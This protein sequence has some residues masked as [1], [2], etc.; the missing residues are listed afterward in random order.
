MHIPGLGTV[1]WIDH[2]RFFHLQRLELLME[3]AQRRL[4]EPG[5]DFAGIAQLAT[6][7]V[8][9][10]QQQRAE[11]MARAFRLGESDDYELLP[12]LAFELDPVAAAPGDIGRPKTLADQALHAHPAGAVEQGVRLLAKRLGEAQQRLVIGL[13]HSC[14]RSPTFFDR[15][16]A[17]VH[18]IEVRQVEQVVENAVAALRLEGVL[19]RLKVRHTLVVGHHHFTIEPRRFQAKRDQGLD[20]FWQFVGPVVAIAGDQPDVAMVDASHDPVAVELDFVAPG[21]VR[22]PVHQRRQFRLEQVR[23]PGFAGTGQWR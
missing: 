2:R 19:Q 9:Q 12:M 7:A 22:D 6:V 10:P 5:A 17:Q 23:Q 1:G 15:H 4:V 21:A 18:A 8:M 3:A 11:G 13:E 16:F 14:Q 20:L